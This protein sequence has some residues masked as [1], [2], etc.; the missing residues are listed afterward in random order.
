MHSGIL[1]MQGKTFSINTMFFRWFTASSMK[2][3]GI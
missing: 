1:K 2:T 3:D